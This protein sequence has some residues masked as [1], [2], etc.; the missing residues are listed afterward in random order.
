MHGAILQQS[1]E[2]SV[3][4]VARRAGHQEG[5]RAVSVRVVAG[6]VLFEMK[7]ASEI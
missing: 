6:T 3:G 1:V 4:G 7:V 2:A 5:H